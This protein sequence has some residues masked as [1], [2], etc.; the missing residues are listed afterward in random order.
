[1]LEV[2]T[3]HLGAVQFEITARNHKIYSDQPAEHG[4]FDEGMTPPELML[5]SLGACAAYYAVDYFKRS[6]LPAEGVACEPQ[7]RFWARR[8]W[9]R[10]I[11]SSSVP[12][13]SP[14][15]NKRACWT[16]FADA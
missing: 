12:T 15:R 10:S 16:L 14:S 2:I 3:N 4:G 5:A 9:T 8:G 6:Q 7:P 11:L 1:M 13:P